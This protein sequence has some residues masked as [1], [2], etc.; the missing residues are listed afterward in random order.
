MALENG[1]F[2]ARELFLENINMINYFPKSEI[3]IEVFR[4]RC[5]EGREGFGEFGAAHVD[6][7]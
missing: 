5:R 6:G 4:R 2:D 7:V 1:N 3:R